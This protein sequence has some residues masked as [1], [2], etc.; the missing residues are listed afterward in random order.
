MLRLV[1]GDALYRRVRIQRSLDESLPL[2]AADQSQIEQVLINLIV[3]GMD[4]MQGTPESARELTVETRVSGADFVEV[5]V[6]DDGC[7]IPAE[8]LPELFDSFFTTK[9]RGHGSGALDRP[10]D[11]ACAWRADLGGEWRQQAAPNSASHCA[12]PLPLRRRLTTSR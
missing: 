3:N 6:I 5:A 9:A 10:L 12:R 2:V 8:R 11:R 7:G 4:A 1:S